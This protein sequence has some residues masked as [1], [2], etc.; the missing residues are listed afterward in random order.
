M[1]TEFSDVLEFGGFITGWPAARLWPIMACLLVLAAYV[2]WLSYRYSVVSLGLPKRIVLVT[3]RTMVFA[4]MLACLANPVRIEKSTVEPPKPP[5]KQS[6][7]SIGRLAVVV[8]RSDSMTT[9]DNRNLTRLDSA[10]AVWRRFEPAARPAYADVRFY[11]FAEDLKEAATL[12]EA[13]ARRGGTDKTCLYA[14]LDELLKKTVEE[15]P[16]AI[17]VLS[18]GIDNSGRSESGL[19]EAAR[20]AG[21]AVHFIAGYNRERPEPFMRVRDFNAPDSVLRRTVFP[22]TV[23]FEAFS[24]DDRVV[25]FSLWSGGRRIDGGSL[26]LTTGANLVPWSC[27]VAADDMGQMDLTLRLEDGPTPRVAARTGVSVMGQRPVNVV[28]YQGAVDWGLRYLTDALQTDPGFELVTVV[29]PALGV[30]LPATPDATKMTGTLASDVSDLSS[31]DC[32]FLVR[33]HVRQLSLRQQQALVNFVRQ[34]GCVIFT[35]PDATSTPQFRGTPLGDL[36]PVVFDE[37]VGPPPATEVKATTLFQFASKKREGKHE[38]GP[39]VLT[40][41]LLTEKGRASP[42]FAAAGSGGPSFLEP[43]FA[44]YARVSRLRPGAELFAI[45]PTERDPSNG[46]PYILLATQTFGFGRTAILT[47]DGLWR[48][49]LSEPSEK[50]VVETFWQQLVLA[51]GKRSVT[52]H[53][54]FLDQPAQVRLGGVASVRLTGVDATRKPVITAVAPD[55]RRGAIEPKP[56]GDP[57]TPWMISW[58]PDIAGAWEFRASVEGDLPASWFTEVTTAS[59]GE[60]ARTPTAVNSMRSIAAATGGLLL[61]DQL[62]LAWRTE[63]KTERKITLKPIVTEKK[64]LRWN[65]WLML[66]VAFGTYALELVL[67]RVWKLL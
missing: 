34:G 57:K 55:G 18:D 20:S 31:G 13:L 23:T 39:S 25:P 46:Q 56:T 24:R 58:K 54:R 35:Q 9:P 19:I 64:H 63:Q 30:S 38:D 26:L 62:P 43:K 27:R 40:P 59:V 49:K 47:T 4:S 33:P 8:D 3:L 51:L 36:L 16:D 42:I 61:V 66:S 37:P 12:D 44:E 7:G 65:N 60:R 45:H 53:I 6:S 67:R 11:S 17:V 22:V 5:K 29:N 41:F 2:A 32:I 50:R 21:V 14:A 28:I 15:R 1:K 10:L 52:E 48:W